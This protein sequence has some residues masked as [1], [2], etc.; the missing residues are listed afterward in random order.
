ME[1]KNKD[2]ILYI[3]KQKGRNIKF[4]YTN[5]IYKVYEYDNKLRYFEVLIDGENK[6]LERKMVTFSPAKPSATSY[7]TDKP[8]DFKREDDQYYLRYA[9]GSIIEIPT[10]KRS[11]Y[12]IFG[13]NSGKIK[14]FV[15]SNKYNIKDTADLKQIIMYYNRLK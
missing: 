7:Q 5:E 15:K 3:R 13:T 4:N 11:F 2:Q 12:D 9:N 6:L 1:F 10:R 14:K 8:A